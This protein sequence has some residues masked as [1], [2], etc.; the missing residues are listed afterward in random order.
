M[1]NWIKISKKALIENHHKIQAFHPEASVCP[2]LKSNAYG[3]GL[4]Q[5]G[6]IF[7][8]LGCPYLIVSNLREASDLKILEVK[9]PIL[10]MGYNPPE[11]LK[12]S[13][14][15]FE[16]FVFDIETVRTLDKYHPGSKIHLFVDTGMTR[17]GVTLADLPDFL[18]KL[19]KFKNLEMVGLCSHFADADNPR[20]LTFSRRQIKNFKTALKIVNDFGF[21]PKWKHVSASSGAFKIHDDT[22]NLIRCGQAH[23]GVS[24]LASGDPYENKLKLRPVLE[25]YSTLVQIKKV[26]KG[27]SV[28]YSRTFVCEKD[29][30]LGLV[31]AG[32][33]EG[34]DR[35]LSN[36][37][38]LKIRKQLFPIVGRVSMNMTVVDITKLK[39]PKIGEEVIV[40]SG[41]S[42]DNNSVKNAS[43][44]AGTIPYEI[45]VH[46]IPSLKRM[47]V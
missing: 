30:V 5:V 12:V 39:N 35:R 14:Y 41:S 29:T 3:H 8:S 2:V 23:Y 19:K 44:Q 9:T 42:K 32:Y 18:G 22:F 16:Y 45:L 17:E 10:V 46:I 26:S 40:Y 1:L 27:T 33:F 38:H 11:A 37:G 13:P 36:I 24:P 20:S 25:L 21:N 34:V 28:G 4:K 31:P 47:V 7:D 43:I 6:P 15:T